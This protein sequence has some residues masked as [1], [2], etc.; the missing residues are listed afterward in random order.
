MTGVKRKVE[1]EYMSRGLPVFIQG[2][3]PGIFTSILGGLKR[4]LIDRPLDVITYTLG[5]LKRFLI[6]R[7]LGVIRGAKNAIKG[8]LATKQAVNS[9]W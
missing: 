4:F 7:P 8:H 3:H 9:W 1:M 6:D 2:A 5:G